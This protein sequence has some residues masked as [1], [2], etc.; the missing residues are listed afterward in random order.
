MA[1]SIPVLYDSWRVLIEERLT[2]TISCSEL[3]V[4][5]RDLEKRCSSRENLGMMIWAT[6]RPEGGLTLSW[7]ASI[8]QAKFHAS[9][10]S[11]ASLFLSRLSG[12]V[13]MKL[14]SSCA[15]FAFALVVDSITFTECPM[16]DG[17]GRSNKAW[18]CGETTAKI[19]ASSLLSSC[20]VVPPLSFVSRIMSSALAC[21]EGRREEY[22]QLHG[23]KL[24]QFSPPCLVG[25]RQRH[26]PDTGP[27]MPIPFE[28]SGTTSE[29]RESQD[30]H[31]KNLL[32]VTN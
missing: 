7:L 3:E 31:L 24:Y 5:S 2:R 12:S 30:P 17:S 10:L 4:R 26:T 18:L 13:E 19:S 8:K 1:L 29:L 6:W 16:R 9:P 32:S 20:S 23:Q 27:L 22:I 28:S 14:I 25:I 15:A 11:W 21:H